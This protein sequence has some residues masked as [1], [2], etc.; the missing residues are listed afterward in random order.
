MSRLIYMKLLLSRS[1]P[2]RILYCNVKVFDLRMQR[3]TQLPNITYITSM[4]PQ[5][6][7]L[8]AR[9]HP[10]TPALW[11]RNRNQGAYHGR[12]RADTLSSLPSQAR[13]GGKR[14]E[15]DSLFI[16][17]LVLSSRF[18]RFCLVAQCRPAV[19]TSPVCLV[20]AWHSCIAP[21]RHL[22]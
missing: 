1:R 22:L 4:V 15:E 20:I 7:L 8:I 2:R 13:K 3:R 10:V 21:S 9:H 18:V 17:K 12:V 6:R 14:E 5:I 19:V 11:S 16:I